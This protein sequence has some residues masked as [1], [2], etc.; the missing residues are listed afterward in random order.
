M[1]SNL[2]HTLGQIFV[3]WLPLP[4][5]GFAGAISPSWVDIDAPYPLSPCA[6]VVFTSTASPHIVTG[7]HSFVSHDIAASFSLFSLAPSLQA[8]VPRHILSNFSF[9]CPVNL[10]TIPVVMVPLILMEHGCCL[11]YLLSRISPICW[12]LLW[13]WTIISLLVIRIWRVD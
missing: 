12:I 8:A 13:T 6:G 10:S 4:D 2:C 11:C 5:Q 1:I 3:V 9:F 7:S